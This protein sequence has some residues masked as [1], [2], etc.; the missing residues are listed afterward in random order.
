[1]ADDYNT[2]T[3]DQPATGTGASA[4]ANAGSSGASVGAG[5]NVGGAGTSAS[6]GAGATSTTGGQVNVMTSEASQIPEA[7]LHFATDSATL[8][9]NA[10]NELLTV[11]QWAKCTPRGALILEGHADPR[12]TQNHNLKL[13]GERAA[14]VRQKLIAMG[15]PSDRIVITVYGE[16][17]PRRATFAQ[18]RRVTV[19]ASD[20]P[21]KPEDIVATR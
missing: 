9:P 5:A 18:D 19:R 7:D 1:M 12:G 21:V 4:G 10:R 15:V 14:M 11:A 8:D 17:G 2:N 3:Y 13:S 16:N 20:R 6:V